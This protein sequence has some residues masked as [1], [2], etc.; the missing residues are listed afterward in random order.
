MIE[1]NCDNCGVANSFVS[2]SKSYKC[3]SCGSLLDWRARVFCNNCQTENRYVRK[4][5][6]QEK[7]RNCKHPLEWSV[8]PQS[9]VPNYIPLRN[10]LIYIAISS[11]ILILSVT[12]AWDGSFKLP[13]GCT[14]Y[15]LCRTA[16]LYENWEMIAPLLSALFGAIG[17]I[18]LVVDH[19][20]RSHRELIYRRVSEWAIGMAILLY[21]ASIF[22]GQ[23]VS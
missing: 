19:Y 22:F 5:L 11:S 20:D 23:R 12:A 16:Y 6:R 8:N 21:F 1:Q 4:H 3:R 15:G 13:H 14:R 10:R 18:V 7:C 9:Y 17:M 2:P